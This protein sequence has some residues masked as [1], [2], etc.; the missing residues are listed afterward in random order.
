V[1]RA[2]FSIV[3]VAF[4]TTAAVIFIARSPAKRYGWA[5]EPF[6]W[7]Y[8]AVLWV[9]GA[10]VVCG[11]MRHVAEIDEEGIVLRPLHRLRRAHIAWTRLRGTEQMIRGDRMIFYFDAE[12][13]MRFVA[14]NLN[15]VK[16]R[17]DFV[18]RIE[19]EL[20]RRGF[21]EKIIERSRYLSRAT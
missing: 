15:L 4:L 10:R 12:S 16:G 11:T 19:E 6:V 3:L 7:L 5:E 21:V 14:L 8:L 20:K 13:G 17:S 1:R 2:G 9:G 18:L